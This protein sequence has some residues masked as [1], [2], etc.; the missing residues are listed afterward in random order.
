MINLF[1]YAAYIHENQEKHSIKN[2]L[3]INE[4]E[5]NQIGT[6]TL[7]LLNGER[8]AKLHEKLAWLLQSL[9]EFADLQGGRLFFSDIWMKQ[10]YCYFEAMHTLR[11]SILAGVNSYFHVSIAGLRSTLEL[12]L[13]HTYWE[14]TK[15]DQTEMSEFREW[16][17]GRVSK[18]PFKRL[19]LN[20][21]NRYNIPPNLALIENIERNYGRL[22]SYAHTPVLRESITK[23]KQTNLSFVDED[24]LI[25]WLNLT[26]DT[27][28]YL[29]YLLIVCYPISI[30]PVRLIRKFG[31]NPPVGLFF[32]TVNFRPLV[33][34]V[35]ADELSSY[36]EWFFVPL[37]IE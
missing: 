27:L 25:Y 15:D 6:H 19:I 32:D 33:R 4:Y 24:V 7:E 21:K 29:L 11:E 26:I 23:I 36:K 20:L 31:F 9:S 17:E 30:F 16:V 2:A 22:C 14:S 34:C 10:G 13:L 28:T 18:L 5:L 37:S 12:L 3:F 1:S 35:S 8:L